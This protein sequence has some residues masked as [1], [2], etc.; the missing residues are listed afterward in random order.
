MRVIDWRSP[1]QQRLLPGLAVL[2]ARRD[3]QAAVRPGGLRQWPA[4]GVH[5]A[6]GV[7][8][9]AAGRL[10]RQPARLPGHDPAALLVQWRRH[11]L[12]RPREP[13]S[14]ASTAAWEHF[15]EWKRIDGRGRERRGLAGDHAA[16]HLRAGPAARPGRELH[17]VRGGQGRADQDGR[18]EPPVLGVNSSIDGGAGRSGRT[19]GGSA[20][21]GT[22]RARARACRWCSS[23]RRCCGSCPATGPS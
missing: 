12:E 22:R 1:G 16:G 2:G 9:A 14:A 8:H 21:S 3:V 13:R 5:R 23:R 10:R 4:A 17:G 15:A 18:Q 20:C 7:A 11:P 19:R 6:E